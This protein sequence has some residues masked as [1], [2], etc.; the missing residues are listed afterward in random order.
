MHH[1]QQ[2]LSYLDD[3]VNGK[4]NWCLKHCQEGDLYI[5]HLTAL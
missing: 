1:G 2:M 5:I 4:A 3:F